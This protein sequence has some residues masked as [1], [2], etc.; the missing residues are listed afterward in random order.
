MIRIID[1]MEPKTPSRQEGRVNMRADG[2][3]RRRICA[4]SPEPTTLAGPGRRFFQIMENS[5]L[6]APVLQFDLQPVIGRL[7]IGRQHRGERVVIEI[8]MQV[9]QN[10][11]LGA[12]EI[13]EG[14]RLFDG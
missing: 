13:D 2:N 7:D 14:Q 11:A 4:D 6:I 1:I 9:G 10:G 8:D 5:P 3:I 12:I